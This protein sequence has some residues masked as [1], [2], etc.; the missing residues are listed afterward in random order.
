MRLIG[1][2]GRH[3]ADLRAGSLAV[4]RSVVLADHVE[5]THGFHAQQLP[6][7][8]ARCRIDLRRA[9]VLD[10]VQQEQIL[11]PPPSRHGEHVPHGRIRCADA[12]GSLRAVVHDPGVQTQ[13]RIVAPAVQRQFL[14]FPLSNQPSRRGSGKVHGRH[15]FH[16]LDL[17]VQLSNLQAQLDGGLLPHYQVDSRL[18]LRRKAGLFRAHFVMAD[19]QRRCSVASRG[20]CH[21]LAKA[22]GLHILNG[23]DCPWQVAAGLIFHNSKQARIGLRPGC[24]RQDRH[25]KKIAPA[26][27]A[28]SPKLS[29]MI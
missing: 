20:I 11:L 17:L 28:V 15:R 29:V 14:H 4:L 9:G 13:Q 10:A 19:R 2:G 21:Q 6:A 7:G 22:T 18:G 26:L 27:H 23:D 3:D 12:A 16:Y 25:E 1:P 8:A 5:L 24:T